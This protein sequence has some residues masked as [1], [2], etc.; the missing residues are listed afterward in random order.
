VH[1]VAEVLS[2]KLRE[3]MLICDLQHA[4][5]ESLLGQE[6]RHGVGAAGV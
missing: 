3:S 4:G 1:L 6:N 2:R 5:K